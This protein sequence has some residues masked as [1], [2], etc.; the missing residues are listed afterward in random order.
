MYVT[1]TVLNKKLSAVEANII[2]I[3]P[4]LCTPP[5]KVPKVR[6]TLTPTPPGCAAHGEGALDL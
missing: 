1:C 4:P 5:P 6:G 2:F 3:G